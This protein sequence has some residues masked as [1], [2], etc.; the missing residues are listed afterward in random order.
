MPPDDH[1][2]AD[3]RSALL[4]HLRNPDDADARKALEAATSDIDLA[5]ART[6]ARDNKD[7]VEAAAAVLAKLVA[8]GEAAEAIIDAAKLAAQK[9]PRDAKG[10]AVAMLAG[11]VI[12]R[13]GEDPK[14]AEPFFRRVRR[15]EAGHP[16]VIAFYRALFA[17]P[18]DASQLMQVLTQ[19]RRAASDDAEL[20]FALAA[21][22]AELAE[23]RLQSADR[24]IE[25]WRS[26]LREDGHD[27][28]VTDALERLYRRAEKHTALVELLKDNVDRM[29][30]SDDNKS[31]RIE[32]LLEISEI[33]RDTLKLDAMALTTLQ[34]VLEIDPR[35][36][37]SLR[38]LADTYA[39]QRRFNDL[40]AIYG[41]LEKVAADDGDQARRVEMLRLSAGI[42]VHELGNPQRALEPLKAVLELEPAD[43]QTR[44]MLASIHEQ[45]RDWRALIDLRRDDLEHLE[46]EDAK[47]RRVD[48]ARISEEKLGDRAA[49]IEMWKS[50]LAHHGESDEALGSLT[51]LYEREGR[52]A[53]AVEVLRQRVDRCSDAVEKVEL[54]QHLGQ[55]CSDRLQDNEGAIEAWRQVAELAP[56]NERALRTL[57]EAYIDGGRWDELTELYVARGRAIKLVDILNGAADRVQSVDERVAL[58]RRVADLCRGQLEEPDRAVKALER[59]LAIQPDNLDVAREL[60]P[61]YES[62]S[63]WSRLLGTNEI[64]LSAAS[65]DDERLALIAEQTRIAGEKMNSPGQAL[66]WAA[67]AYKLRPEDPAIREGLERA[68][69]KADG[70]D[71]LTRIFEARIADEASDDAEKL[72]LLEKLAG[73]ARDRLFKPDDAQ[74]YYRRII[75]LDTGNAAALDALES[76]YSSTRR[77]EDLAGVYQTRLENTADPDA[78]L[79][80]LRALASLQEQQL[81]DLEA[82]SQ[83]HTAILDIN[84]DDDNALVALTKIYRSR[85][86]WENLAV[87]LQRRLD[88][89]IEGRARIDALFELGKL[90]ALR[91]RDS[92]RAIDGFLEILELDPTHKGAVEQLEALRQAEPATALP[93]SR[94]LLPYYQ[95]VKDRVREAEAM[96][97]LLAAETDEAARLEQQTELAGIYD[98]MADRKSDALRMYLQLF[99][100]TPGNWDLRHNCARLGRELGSMELVANAYNE[101]L[102]VLG[103][104]ASEAEQAGRTLDRDAAHLRRDLLLE[105]AELLRDDLGDRGSAES[106]YAEVLEYE[107]E[108]QGAYENLQA[109]LQARGADR[110]LMEL[111][112]RRVDVIFNQREQRELLGRIIDLA[113]NKLGERELAVRTAEE[114]LDL[115]PDDLP[116]IQ[117]LG[118][119]YYES[120]DPND[121]A[122]L[123][124]LLGRWAEMT[125]DRT[126]RHKLVCRR[127]EVRV[128]DLGDAFGAV[129]LLGQVLGEDAAN[130]D[131]RNLLE[132]LL[133]V[134]EVQSQVA[135]L[136]EPIYQRVGDHEGRV[137]ILHVRRLKA[138]AEGSVDRATSHLLEIA[139][140]AEH[141]QKDP[142]RAFEV[143]RQ[144]FLMDPRRI[145]ARDELARLGDGLRRDEELVEAWQAALDSDRAQDPQLRIELVRRRAELLDQRIQDPVRAREAFIELLALDPPD[146][147]LAHRTVAALCR[148]HL[149]AGDFVALV[150]AKRSLLRFTDD[151][152]DQVSLRL[153][154]AHIQLGALFD[155]VGAAITWS[156]VIDREPDNADALDALEGLFTEES[157]W[158]RLIEVLNHRVAVTND[159]RRQAQWWRRIG[160]LQ[161]EKLEDPHGA[162]DAYASVLDLRVGRDDTLYAL[163]KLVDVNASLERWAD[164]EE[165]QKRLIALADDDATRTELL[166]E[167]AEVV[168]KRL[169]RAADALES[170]KRVLDLSP[171]DARARA[172]V[173]S[174]LEDDNQRERAIRILT[175]LYEAE[176]NWASL[177]ELQELQARKQPSG[178]RRL[179]ALLAVAKTQEERLQDDERAFR[180]LCEAMVE[181]GDQ[182]ELAEILEKIE[183][184]GEKPERAEALVDAYR[185]TSDHILDADLQQRVY[186]RM[187]SVSLERVGDLETAKTAFLRVHEMAPGDKEAVAALEQIYLR[188]EDHRALAELLVRSAERESDVQA[189]DGLLVRAAEIH[190]TKLDE[191]ERAIELYQRVSEKGMQRPDVVAVI[192][193]LYEQ[194]GRFRD[195]AAHLNAK[196]GALTGDALVDTHLRLG[197][198]F[199]EQL[200]DPEEGIR[201]LGTAV[202]LNP[203]RAVDGADLDRYLEDPAMRLRAAEMLEPVFAGI[204]D[205]RRLVHIQ[206]IRLAEAHDPEERIK[207]LLRIAQLQEDQ[208]EDLAGAFAG[209]ARVFK[210][211]PAN[212]HVRDQLHRLA[213][214]LEQQEQYA[215]LLTEYVQGDAETDD[216]DEVLAIVREAGDMWAMNLRKPARAVPLYERLVRA[217]SDD[218]RAFAALESALTQAG[219]HR[220]LVEAYWRDVDASLDERRQIDILSRIA[221]V[222][223]DTLGEPEEA[224]RAYHRILEIDPENESARAQLEQVV[225][226]AERWDELLDLLRDRLTRTQ[227]LGARQM[228]ALQM[229]E[230]QDQTIDDPDGA[231]DTLE[232]MLAEEPSSPEAIMALEQIAEKRAGQRRRVFEVLEPIYEA[233]GN[234]QRQIAVLEWKLSVEQDP[235]DRHALY[236]DLADKVAPLDDG[237]TH[238]LRVLARAVREPGPA[239]AL[240]E[241]DQRL[242]ALGEGRPSA[243]AEALAAAAASDQL[244]NDED[245]VITLRVWAAR[246]QLEAGA[247]DAAAEAARAATELRPDHEGALALLDD[248]LAKLG[249]HDEM[250]AVLARRAELTV[251]D[252]K[253]AELLRRLARLL[254]EVLA[255]PA[256]AEGVWRKLLEAA[257]DDAEALERLSR[258]YEQSGSTDEL[259]D[260]L[261]RRVESTTD[262]AGRRELRMQLAAIHREGAKDRRAEID[263]LRELLTE[264]P[265]DDDALAAL[266]RALLAEE[267]HADAVD[268]L[269]D[270]ATIAEA[271]ERKAALTLEAARLCAGPLE[272][273]YGALDRY[274]QV[275]SFVPGHDGAL[276]DLVA[277]VEDETVSERVARM[278]R[279]P[280]EAQGRFAE[281]AEVFAAR[282]RLSQD[283]EE[284]ANLL[285][286]LA[287]VRYEKLDDP[288]GALDA[289]MRL[290][291]EA[292]IEQVREVLGAARRLAAELGEVEAHIEGV[293]QGAEQADDPRRAAVFATAAAE[294]LSTLAANDVAAAE[295]LAPLAKDGTL[296]LQGCLRLERFAVA[297][298]RPDLAVV[299]LSAAVTQVPPGHESPT[300]LELLVRLG[301]AR[302]EVGD[303]QG[304][305]DAYVDAL[306]REPGHGPALGGMEQVMQ[307]SGDKVPT[308]VL[309]V[310]D[311][312]Y[313]QAGN[314]QGM[315]H[316]TQLR[317]N[318]AEGSD[319]AEL[320]RNLGGL[321]EQGA[322]DPAAALET[323]GSL[324][325]I[326]AEAPEALDKLRAAA[327]DLALLP[328]A[329]SL[330]AAAVQAARNESRPCGELV[331]VAAKLNLSAGDSSA[332]MTMLDEELEQSSNPELLEVAV[333]AARAGQDPQRLHDVLVRAAESHPDP[334]QA[335]NAWREAASVAETGLNDPELA[336]RDL[337]A[338]VEADATNEAGW[339]K[340]TAQLSSMER[341][342]QLA[343]VLEQRV[344][345][346]TDP[347][348]RRELRYRLA[349]LLVGKLERP[350]DAVDV[351]NDMISDAPGDSAAMSELEVVLRRM[352]RWEDVRELAERKLQA[353]DDPEARRAIYAGMAQLCVNRLEDKGE[354]ISIWQRS[355]AEDPDA[356]QAAEALRPLLVAE[357]RWRDLAELLRDRMDRARVADDTERFR[358]I[359]SELAGVLAERLDAQSEAEGILNELLEVDPNYVPALVALASVHEARGDD[360][361]MR[362][363]LERAVATGPE[364]AA[365]AKLQ[366]KLAALADDEETRRAHLSRALECE[367]GNQAATSQLLELAREAGR[368]DEVVRLLEMAVART[369]DEQERR[370]LQ[371]ER[372]DTLYDRLGDVDGGLRALA[373]IYEQ[374]QDDPEVNRR[375]ADG[376]YRLERW[377]EAG[378]MYAWLVEVSTQKRSKTMASY[379]T[380][381]GNIEIVAGQADSGEK[382]LV[383]AY[384]MDTTNVETLVSLGK[385]YE[386]KENW[387][388]ALK[389]YR[390]MLLQNADRSGLIRRGDI[391]LR[392]SRVHVALDE[393]PKAQAM[394][395]RGMEEDPEYGILSQ[396]LTELQS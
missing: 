265:S 76:I 58:Y 378:G 154:I 292:P 270:R 248:A 381:L 203:A 169:G 35:H 45:R 93:I 136:L 167:S 324:L 107:E 102:A 18:N 150:D 287:G 364:G 160:D 121:R 359:A 368:W 185:R 232:S 309:D 193:P 221:N 96:E 122:A 367:P 369:S 214:I 360:A 145:D 112:R 348:P 26:V 293:K 339:E 65:D 66:S 344:T 61:I 230:L 239:S 15:T 109:L 111:Y 123:E 16:D 46:G 3:P 33:Y 182:P 44:D 229:A 55:I 236:R 253:R 315:A 322:G 144:A 395:R 30:A 47:Q 252:E 25:V 170:L 271:P 263:V 361:Q 335:A 165:G 53:D 313:R 94:G 146:F 325:A 116:T 14:V 375:I 172:M 39:K 273:K 13:V 103:H 143:M 11:E 84:P 197:R 244:A 119:M 233:Q 198:L 228:V 69:E 289:T 9:A 178:R 67:R 63:S 73:V 141:E 202:R 385:V 186:R 276:K 216:S 338:V 321:M 316:I 234:T 7:S 356:T 343:D 298:H 28:R 341:H 71:E 200:D 308:A 89:G 124:E 118:R 190:R 355:L 319:K 350:A 24:A 383:E 4:E 180:V 238:A 261:R 174:F 388:E 207:L 260:V 267:Q 23:E 396:T 220:E 269:I 284:R 34:R 255:Q 95:R 108:H 349:N 62:A 243:L 81:R 240:E 8:E 336:L 43:R 48:L 192:E 362:Q 12:W 188:G 115:I 162:L 117:L 323:W 391:Y 246:L 379:L 380:R 225:A 50:V 131:A 38:A 168:G 393:R 151:H 78:R 274:E 376:L 389:I 60:I 59:I 132:Q 187:G 209:Y 387:A 242:K 217:H 329:A 259:V 212:R 179:Q 332:A 72:S 106:K 282:A 210:E 281:L 215:E 97:I 54:L 51:R 105:L 29:E 312:A 275:F 371:L 280:L 181:A 283:P 306:D 223:R 345:L 346:T 138:E 358:M 235:H 372:V 320:L 286:D 104:Q 68:A 98:K 303:F 20:R 211:Q 326:D 374:V 199:G 139:R 158:R 166:I 213:A 373:S 6:E 311:D 101:A 142:G 75:D 196:L 49:A 302:T 318:Q 357:E 42:W 205:W 113:R 37:E 91:L 226:Q 56:S 268:V 83:T 36:D 147:E 285:R 176:Q 77:W 392:L 354:A 327:E 135:D 74:R 87:V 314:A 257:P 184:L 272:D 2:M 333:Q 157:E 279:E 331:A 19:A 278:L 377:Q 164:V 384:R 222:A 347:E 299:G 161:R 120:H 250:R 264:Q 262:P 352:E 27:D 156:E 85:G 86:D 296:G 128:Q 342:E 52:W 40:L 266:G 224:A 288:R 340:L 153:E 173:G 290:A 99:E 351:Y 256:E 307:A 80:T 191:G 175:P 137:R 110:E 390:A 17:G 70:W 148:L 177:V 334:A 206:E 194:T 231:L 328:R 189:R 134:A 21:E 386:S 294:A 88:L 79:E 363:A 41:R 291:A 57:R 10:N 64:L 365:G 219:M 258:S 125:D 297:A 277:L 353:T 5:A 295:L 155:R 300:E 204:G 130:P 149:E 249:H 90:H 22:M 305:A 32:K 201:H 195:L 394:L 114:L 218:T 140:I 370:R 208:L 301:R 126:M 237:A 304:A 241:L 330:A 337:Q 317:L 152:A 310:L 100:A 247:P 227:D 127:A 92:D 129:D 254:E 171:T 159:P 245:R 82:A 133:D 31:E 1:T 366:L 163:R 382:R 183:R 251:D